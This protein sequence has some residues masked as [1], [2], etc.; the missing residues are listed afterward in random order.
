MLEVLRFFCIRI[1]KK[2][3]IVRCNSF[4]KKD[5]SFPAQSLLPDLYALDTEVLSLLIILL[6]YTADPLVLKSLS[7]SDDIKVKK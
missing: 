4:P 1:C 5:N 3:I 6:H 2:R 7:T